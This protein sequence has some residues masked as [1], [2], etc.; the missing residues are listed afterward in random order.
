[1]IVGV[2]LHENG[3]Q[4]AVEQV[5]VHGLVG[6]DDDAEGKLVGRGVVL[7]DVVFGLEV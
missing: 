7:R 3:V 2:I 1:M 6:G 5:V 4:V